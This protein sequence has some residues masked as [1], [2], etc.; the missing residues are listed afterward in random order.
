MDRREQL[1]AW[2]T[3]L[4]SLDLMTFPLFGVMNGKCRCR[5]GVNCPNPG[6]HPKVKGWRSLSVPEPIG[7]LDNLG[8]ATDKL[9]V[10]DFDASQTRP[11]DLPE[12]FTVFTARGMHLW[13]WANPSHPIRNAT[14]WRPKVDIRSV[15]G[16]VACP[17]SLTVKGTE[18]TYMGGDIQPVPQVVLDTRDKY[19]ARERRSIKQ[20]PSETPALMESMAEAL[21]LEVIG[22]ASGERNATLFRVGC[23]FFELAEGG[24][25]GADA[26]NLIIEAAVHVGLS[27]TEARATLDSASRN[28]SA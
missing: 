10:L 17:P 11:P 3:Y 22:A 2:Q 12:T 5:E 16:L 6:K 14:G 13:Y 20:I 19:V 21:A 18:Y 7:A 1:D 15:G 28:L 26:L 9:V 24:W 4:T 8:V 27:P 23:R 25:L